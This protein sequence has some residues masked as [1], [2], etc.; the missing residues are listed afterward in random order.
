MIK[1]YIYALC[2]PDNN[3]IRYIGQSVD[4][5]S[6]LSGHMTECE[7][8]NGKKALWLRELKEQG[9]KPNILILETCDNDVAYKREMYYIK[10]YRKS[11]LILNDKRRTH[12]PKRTERPEGL[13]RIPVMLT[14]ECI[15]NLTL[16]AIYKDTK[17]K[18]HA[19]NILENYAKEL[20][21]QSHAE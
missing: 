16:A 9:K 2:D 10:K 5:V 15:K 14:P 11:G 1:V 13:L 3:D 4:T 7:T 12:N 18:N 8:N 17:F 20:E 19:E 21:K 6:R